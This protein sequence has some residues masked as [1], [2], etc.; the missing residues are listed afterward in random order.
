KGLIEALPPG[1]LEVHARQAFQRKTEEPRGS[2][3][4]IK[5]REQGVLNVASK[6]SI[7]H[8][9]GCTSKQ[10]PLHPSVQLGRTASELTKA[11]V[12]QP[13][14]VSVLYT[15]CLSCG[16]YAIGEIADKALSDTSRWT[17]L[18]RAKL[19]A[20]VKREIQAGRILCIV[21]VDDLTAIIADST[22]D[23]KAHEW[24]Q[25]HK[26]WLTQNITT[27]AQKMVP[28]KKESQD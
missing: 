15:D 9:W 2:D 1:R 3:D 23:E 22:L 16:R 19:I 28:L 25:Q 13:E 27:N 8:S 17:D 14:L 4:R 11:A 20:M 7:C 6:C 10:G 24:L 21:S 12:K 5:I 18:E 26:D